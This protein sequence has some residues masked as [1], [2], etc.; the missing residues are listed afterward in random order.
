M[1]GGSVSFASP[2]WVYYVLPGGLLVLGA[3]VWLGSLLRGRAGRSLAPGGALR[4]TLR[5]SPAAR[6]A[7]LALAAG[8]WSL[9]CVALGR[10]QWGTRSERLPRGGTDLMILVDVSNSMLVEDMGTSR[11]EWALRKIAD[12][13]DEMSA[14]PFHRVGLMPFAGEPFP[15]VPP[16]PDYEAVRFF[17]DDV[18]PRSVGYGGSNLARAIDRASADLKKAPGRHRAILLISDGDAIDPD[19]SG[20]VWAARE[21]AREK[22]VEAARDAGLGGGP[23]VVVFTLGVGNDKVASEVA[24]PDGRG[25]RSYVRYRNESGE[26]RIATSRLDESTLANIASA[27]NGT[28]VHSTYDDTDLQLL[29]ASGLLTGG[30]TGEEEASRSLP[31]DRFRWPLL[32]AFV[33]LLAEMFVPAGGRGRAG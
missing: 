33:L 12:L 32:A 24:V 7:K 28:Y 27:G 25:G 14:E 31:I 23:K 1:D 19:E 18:N 21:V 8:A 13:L 11:L 10:P 3:L 5:S 20:A 22:A 15:L 9:L 6:A 16:T 30:V 29:V 4:I 2:W 17:L 26:E